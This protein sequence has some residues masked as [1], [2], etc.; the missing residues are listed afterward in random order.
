[1]RIFIHPKT[2]TQTLWREKKGEREKEPEG[3]RRWRWIY[4]RWGGSQGSV[5]LL[6]VWLMNSQVNIDYFNLRK[7]TS[8]TYKEVFKSGADCSLIINK[9]QKPQW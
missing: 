5:A 3:G 2:E 1:M 7:K 4:Q 6:R 9:D 8:C